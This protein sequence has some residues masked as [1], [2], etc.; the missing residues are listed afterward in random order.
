MP[1]ERKPKVRVER[2][3]PV[4]ALTPRLVEFIERSLGGRS[5]D[6]DGDVEKRPDFECLNGLLAVEIKSLE[7]DPSDRL[8]TA[9]L[10]DKNDANWPVF[11]G[12][13][14]F[15]SIKKHLDNVDAVQKKLLDRLGRALVT[16]V[17][18]AND[19]LGQHAAR[20]KRK[21]LVRLMMLVNEDYSEYEPNAVAFLVQREL[22]RRNSD[23]SFRNSQIDAVIF[24]SERHLAVGR[25][26]PILPAIV[27]CGVGMDEN[28]WKEDI[29]N[30]VLTRWAAWNRAPILPDGTVTIEKFVAAEHVPDQMARH[31]FWALQYRRKPYM[32]NWKDDDLRDLWDHVMLISLLRLHRDS[33]MKVPQDGFTQLMER[34]THLREE[35][36]VRGLPLEYFEKDPVSRRREVVDKMPYGAKVAS[37]LHATLDHW[38]DGS[39]PP[40]AD[41]K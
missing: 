15:D 40:K 31:E 4:E 18:K 41:E 3:G 35:V 6:E 12:P 13:W 34:F 11:F 30:L 25:K 39:A 20:V 37:W 22:S 19:Q 5:L 33:P 9:V 17:K 7:T 16:H 32:R 1:E 8:E 26:G 29:V 36:A 10:P 38:G 23:G 2:H 21:N 14:P 27:I 24:L 28:L